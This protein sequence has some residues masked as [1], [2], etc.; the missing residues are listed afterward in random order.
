MRSHALLW[1]PSACSWRNLSRYVRQ[2]VSPLPSNPRS[3]SADRDASLVSNQPSF[4]D[5]PV[6]GYVALSHAAPW[7]LPL[8]G[9]AAAPNVGREA[10]VPSSSNRSR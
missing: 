2:A 6:L 10:L 9:V 3:L 8:V 7:Q 5:R 4:L 1:P